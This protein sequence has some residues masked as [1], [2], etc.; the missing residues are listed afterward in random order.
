MRFAIGMAILVA[1][2][3]GLACALWRVIQKRKK[4]LQRGTSKRGGIYIEL[5]PKDRP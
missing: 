3:V 2:A 1:I 5:A 4:L